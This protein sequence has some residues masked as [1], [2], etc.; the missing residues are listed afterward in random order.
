MPL[1]EE[2]T[3][4]LSHSPHLYR[5][6]GAEMELTLRDVDKVNVFKSP[7]AYYIGL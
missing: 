6:N 7:K 2:V 4:C 5:Y 1:T 3:L